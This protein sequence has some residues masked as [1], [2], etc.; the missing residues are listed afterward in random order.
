MPKES[1]FAYFE[2]A[3]ALLEKHGKRAA[4]RSDKASIFRAVHTC[5]D[6]GV[7][8]TQCGQVL[9]EPDIDIMCANTAQAKR[10]VER[11]SLTLWDRLAKEL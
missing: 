4:L 2:A 7:R 5:I 10:R 8:L 6:F 11:L 9:D 1:A 3:R